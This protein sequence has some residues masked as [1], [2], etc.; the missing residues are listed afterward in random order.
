MANPILGLALSIDIKTGGAN[1]PLN[2]LLTTS[3]LAKLTPLAFKHTVVY[4][5]FYGS[6]MLPLHAK[7]LQFGGIPRTSKKNATYIRDSS[8][9]QHTLSSPL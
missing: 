9:A 4:P 8:F 7:T 3:R 5:A 6:E 2:E 1:T